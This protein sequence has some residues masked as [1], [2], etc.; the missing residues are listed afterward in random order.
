MSGNHTTAT[1]GPSNPLHTF[2][3]KETKYLEKAQ[4][5]SDTAYAEYSKAKDAYAKAQNDGMSEGE[6]DELRQKM[7]GFEEEARAKEEVLRGLQDF[8]D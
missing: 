1:T 5:E 6:V 7:Y 2:S 4:I 3:S 8:C